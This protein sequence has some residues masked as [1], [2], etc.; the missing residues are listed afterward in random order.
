MWNMNIG[1]IVRAACRVC[2]LRIIYLVEKNRQ[3]LTGVGSPM[4]LGSLEL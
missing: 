4:I 3:I 2:R 1:L